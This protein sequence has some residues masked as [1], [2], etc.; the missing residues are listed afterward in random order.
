M[1]NFPDLDK[2]LSAQGCGHE[3]LTCRGCGLPSCWDCEDAGVAPA[4]CPL[5][6]GVDC[7]LGFLREIREAFPGV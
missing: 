3:I 6:R 5:S 2:I 1:P 4:P 7:H